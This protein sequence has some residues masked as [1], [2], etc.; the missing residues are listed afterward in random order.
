MLRLNSK[1]GLFSLK[2]AKRPSFSNQKAII[3]NL[4]LVINNPPQ[5]PLKNDKNSTLKANTK[6]IITETGMPT[7][8]K[9]K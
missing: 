6:P 7:R 2:E 3:V 4:P 8:N 9:L 5:N 1:P